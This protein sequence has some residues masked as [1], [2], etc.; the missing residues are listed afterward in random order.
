MP[1]PDCCLLASRNV[2]FSTFIFVFSLSLPVHSFSVAQF[3][4]LQIVG[5]ESFSVAGGLH[6]PTHQHN[7]IIEHID[8]LRGTKGLTQARIVLVPESNYAWESQRYA[9]DIIDKNVPNIY[10]MDEDDKQQGVR[11]DNKS[12]K[13]MAV[14]FGNAL[15]ASL[16]KFHPLLVSVSGNRH[17][18]R[19]MLIRQIGAYKQKRI[20]RKGEASE[21]DKPTEIYTGKIGGHSDDHCVMVQLAYI[22]HNIYRNKYEEKYKH[23]KPLGPEVSREALARPATVDVRK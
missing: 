8:A 23:Q 14:L 7:L 22:S 11:T 21:Y 15:N 18:M 19:D 6:A 1:G 12:K 16:I 17:E 13:L 5:I 2:K 4:H 9:L 3:T 20:F 10:L